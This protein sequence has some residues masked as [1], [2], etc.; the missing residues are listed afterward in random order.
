MHA[1]LSEGRRQ[2]GLRRV[3]LE[4]DLG[5][6]AALIEEAFSGEMDAGGRATVR[7]LRGLSRLGPLLRLAALGDRMLRGI[8]QGFVWEENGQIVGNVTL[9]PADYPPELG[10]TIII[11]NVAVAPPYRRRGIARQLMQAALEAVQA[12]GG[13]AAILEVEAG[14]TG[15]QQ[16]YTGLGFRTLR[17]WHAWRR[18]S[19]APLPPRHPN[20]PPITLRPEALWPAEYAMAARVFPQERGGLGW[21]RPLHPREFHRSPAGR[22]VDFLSGTGTERWIV[23]EGEQVRGSLWAR[24]SFGSGVTQLTLIVPPEE[25]GRLEA[26]LLSYGVR[27][28]APGGRALTCEHPAD[29]DPAGEA[30]RRCGFSIRRT[31]THM[32]LDF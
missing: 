9:F 27:R 30:L 7:E 23:R 32:R 22:I 13:Q 26:P 20:G 2:H 21:Q 29:D 10:R 11:A 6:I 15:A 18:G 1:A 19:E 28:L 24:T 3:K 17:T 31:L 12:G 5:A 4:R 8:G 16:L 25:K 14:N